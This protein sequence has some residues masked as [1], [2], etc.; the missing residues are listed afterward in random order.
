M[1]LM[2]CLVDYL[3]CVEQM[4][5]SRGGI[6]DELIDMFTLRMGC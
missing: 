3:S 1:D 4:L 6:L 2:L 5:V